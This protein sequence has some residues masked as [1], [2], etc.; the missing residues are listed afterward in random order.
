[1]TLNTV[2]LPQVSKAIRTT[3]DTQKTFKLC[4]AWLFGYLN[5][6]ETIEQYVAIRGLIKMLCNTGLFERK[7]VENLLDKPAPD[8]V[9]RETALYNVLSKWKDLSIST[10]FLNK[11]VKHDNS[12]AM[13]QLVAGSVD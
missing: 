8:V 1:V 9:E 6:C 13:K 11:G 10:Y 12:E 3:Y 4:L 5:R 7:S 2:N